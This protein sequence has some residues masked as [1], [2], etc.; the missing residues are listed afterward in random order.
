MEN[1]GCKCKEHT[2]KCY[3]S[4]TEDCYVSD[5]EHKLIDTK[6]EL[7]AAQEKIKRLEA[8]VNF[9]ETKNFFKA[10]NLEA[11][12]QIKRWGINHDTG[13]TPEEW[14]WLLAYLSTKATQAA[15]YCDDGKYKHHIIICAAACLNWHRNVT[16]ENNLMKLGS[17]S[18]TP[19]P[20]SFSLSKLIREHNNIKS[21]CSMCEKEKRKIQQLE[22]AI[23]RF[24]KERHLPTLIIRW[25]AYKEDF[26]PT[27]KEE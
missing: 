14:L 26:N 24:L 15:R 20:T 21:S 11:A 1:P 22:Y 3:S 4:G 12:H 8:L 16:G 10:I 5:M 17:N 6:S 25:D 9:P 7:T 2:M 27:K 13:K 23:R 18:P 19:E